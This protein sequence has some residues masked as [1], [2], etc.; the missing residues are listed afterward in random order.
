MDMTQV[1]LFFSGTILICLSAVVAVIAATVIN[2]IIHK[3]WK[4][5]TVFN[6][7]PSRFIEETELTTKTEP[8]TIKQS[9]DNKSKR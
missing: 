2:N 1:A 9:I 5:I 6:F 3:Y 4:P 7:A 8:T